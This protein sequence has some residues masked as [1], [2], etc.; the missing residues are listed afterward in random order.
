MFSP[1]PPAYIHLHVNSRAWPI[2]DQVSIATN[3][4][5]TN[6]F[7]AR[8]STYLARANVNLAWPM[9]FLA[10]GNTFLL[11]HHGPET[12]LETNQ[13]WNVSGEP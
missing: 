9:V 6:G 8:P 13:A 11:S 10:W 12:S 2:P 4:V 3:L 5:S 7:L 1:N